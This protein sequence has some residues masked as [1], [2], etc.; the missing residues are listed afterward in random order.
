MSGCPACNCD[1][2][3]HSEAF[4]EGV[5]WQLVWPQKLK[6]RLCRFHLRKYEQIPDKPSEESER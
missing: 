5:A 4:I 1:D 2:C 6:E 3:P